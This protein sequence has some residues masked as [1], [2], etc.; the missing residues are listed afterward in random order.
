MKVN[1]T[2]GEA[3]HAYDTMIKK[4]SNGNVVIRKYDKVLHCIDDGYIRTN[5]EA[6]F[7][8]GKRTKEDSKYKTI[9]PDSL[10]RTRNLIIDYASENEK[11]WYSFITLTYAEN[12]QDI[13]LANKQFHNWTTCIKRKYPD[14]MYL[15]VQEVQNRGAIHFH[16]L[17]NIKCGSELIPLQKGKKCMYDVK[18]WKHGYTSA[19]DIINGVDQHFNVALYMV[20]YLYKDM[21]DRLFGRNKILKSNNLKKPE[22]K[23]LLADSE[24]Y[25]NAINYIKEKG[26]C[27]NHFVYDP[28]TDYQIP[29]TQFTY[30]M[31]EYDTTNE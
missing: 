10:T 7:R 8:V 18:Y 26:T 4:Y 23:K 30:S 16:V 6:N 20:K 3:S 5:K 12:V 13:N 15:G 1:Y 19:R 22:V 14:F 29:F 2:A 27:I 28:K 31:H 21:S 25:V 11:H 24:T 9:R 17:T